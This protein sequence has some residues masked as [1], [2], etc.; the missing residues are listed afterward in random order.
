MRLVVIQ[1]LRLFGLAQ[2]VAAVT[3]ETVIQGGLGAALGG[4]FDSSALLLSWGRKIS[5]FGDLPNPAKGSWEH[6]MPAAPASCRP[7]AVPRTTGTG[8]TPALPAVGLRQGS[9]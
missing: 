2:V 7:R 3:A 4:E 6:L 9:Q 8:G 5:G 1:G